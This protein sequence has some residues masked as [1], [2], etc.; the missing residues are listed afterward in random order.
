MSLG[1][2]DRGSGGYAQYPP[3][4]PIDSHFHALLP[5]QPTRLGSAQDAGSRGD[6]RGSISRRTASGLLN[7]LFSMRDVGGILLMQLTN[8][9][10]TGN[11]PT[12][13]FAGGV[14]T[15]IR[16]PEAVRN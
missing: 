1:C 11:A 13:A 3:V 14:N 7:M 10:L 2:Y 6:C 15:S 9:A 16:V 12:R 5:S 8:P 4:A